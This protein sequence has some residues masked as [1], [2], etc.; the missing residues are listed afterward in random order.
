MCAARLLRQVLPALAALARCGRAVAAFEPFAANTTAALF[1]GDS[2]TAEWAARRHTR[3]ARSPVLARAVAA[4]GLCWNDA[5]CSF[6][7]DWA[8]SPT[9]RA[10]EDAVDTVLASGTKA[11]QRQAA[12]AVRRFDAPAFSRAR[13]SGGASLAA[14]LECDGYAAVDDWGLAPRFLDALRREVDEKFHQLAEVRLNRTSEKDR[15]RHKHEKQASRLLLRGWPKSHSE[16][17][18]TFGEPLQT[19]ESEEGRRFLLNS[20]LLQGVRDY[21]GDETTLAGYA[22]LR[23]TAELADVADYV[24]GIWHHDR[25]GRRLK[26][27]LYLDDVQDA[28]AERP[29]QVARASQ[30]TAYWS[31][32]DMRE[33][34]YA[35][36]WVAARYDV[37]DMLGRAGGGFVFDTN[38][39][40]RGRVEG[41][42]ARTVLVLEFNPTAKAQ[43]LRRVDGANIPCP[44]GPMRKI[45]ASIAP[46]APTWEPK[47][48][49]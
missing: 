35:H 33:S 21:L 10:L 19:L 1:W 15:R 42:Q 34:R 49:S 32:H 20:T 30:R 29:T 39:L 18:L 25:C 26:A 38:A 41:T 4:G 11:S 14:R 22:A 8:A 37:E 40:H 48:P 16:A 27:F 17:V 23:L 45:N 24:S 9:T 5:G 12:A 7:W 36:A 2:M 43:A 31:Y 28:A 6:G 46:G 47:G 3:A 13:C 44:S